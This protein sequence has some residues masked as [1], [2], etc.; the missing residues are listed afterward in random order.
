MSDLNSDFQIVSQ[1]NLAPQNNEENL[2]A[3]D[4]ILILNNDCFLEIFKYLNVVDL[5]NFSDTCRRIS[6]EARSIYKKYSEIKY[7]QKVFDGV[8]EAIVYRIF[9]KIGHYLSSLAIN[10]GSDVKIC[11]NILKFCRNVRRLKYKTK[12]LAVDDR[13]FQ[14]N[15]R[16]FLQLKSLEIHNCTIKNGSI[17]GDQL[18]CLTLISC[19]ILWSN[20]QPLN[21]VQS[22]TVVKC[23]GTGL[24]QL[25]NSTKNIKTLV[26]YSQG[27]LPKYNTIKNVESLDVD[28]NVYNKLRLKKILQLNRLRILRVIYHSEILTGQFLLRLAKKNCGLE[29]L[30]LYK[31]KVDTTVMSAWKEFKNLKILNLQYPIHTNGS[32]ILY[33]ISQ[34]LPNLKEF[35][36]VKSSSVSSK[37]IISFINSMKMVQKLNFCKCNI[38]SSTLNDINDVIRSEPNRK[39]QLITNSILYDVPEEVKFSF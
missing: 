29:E 25:T 26:F 39:L 37:G 13:I 17:F 36:F 10:F 18:E 22:L 8:N 24:T 19:R 6:S 2:I 31:Q 12:G 14:H 35:H 27:S 28:V 33:G 3:R 16:F 9:S 23:S 7:S 20:F 21:S 11:E 15:Q 34:A 1:N 32:N 4:S 5:L 30:H 38:T